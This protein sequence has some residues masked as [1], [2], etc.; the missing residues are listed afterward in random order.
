MC[1]A[2]GP[3]WAPR[4]C[5]SFGLTY[6]TRVN[7]SG[8]R[9]L[10]II[11]LAKFSQTVAITNLDTVLELTEAG[12]L[13]PGFTVRGLPDLALLRRHQAVLRVRGEDGLTEAADGC[14][15]VV[16]GRK[17]AASRTSSCAGCNG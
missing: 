12:E 1:G 13:C 7:S 6:R 2:C 15:D 16:V 10:E 14:I 4:L 17:V 11:E 8:E 5:A 3:L 9:Y